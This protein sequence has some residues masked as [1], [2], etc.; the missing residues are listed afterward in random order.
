MVRLL[1]RLDM[2]M[3]VDWDVKP[4]N[5]QTKTI[6]QSLNDKF[7]TP[8]FICQAVFL[9][10]HGSHNETLSFQAGLSI[11]RIEAKFRQAATL[12]CNYGYINIRAGDLLSYVLL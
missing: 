8:H 1:D 7:L 5:K 2:T 9:K 11:T 3:V 6:F 10:I 12:P 4:Q